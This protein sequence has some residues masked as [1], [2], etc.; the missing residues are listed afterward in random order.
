MNEQ[1]IEVATWVLAIF[2]IVLALATIALAYFTWRYLKVS[3]QILRAGYEQSEATQKLATDIR[4]LPQGF[5]NL[6]IQIA[7]SE[8][9]KRTRTATQRRATG[10]K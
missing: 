2:T 10:Q 7:T 5:R 8:E 3:N 4:N 9:S 6:Q 1:S